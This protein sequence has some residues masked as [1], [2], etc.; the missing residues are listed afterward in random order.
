MSLLSRLMR[1]LPQAPGSG[2]ARAGVTLASGL[3]G[4][5]ALV[6]GAAPDESPGWSWPC[7]HLGHPWAFAGL[8]PQATWPWLCSDI[9]GSDPDGPSAK[10][11]CWKRPVL[12][13][14]PTAPRVGRRRS[15]PMALSRIAC[16]VG[17]WPGSRATG[18]GSQ[19][20]TDQLSRGGVRPPSGGGAGRTR[21]PSRRRARRAGGGQ[22]ARGGKEGGRAEG[23]A[24][25][26]ERGGRAAERPRSGRVPCPTT[27]ARASSPTCGGGCA[28]R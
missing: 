5:P 12:T 8:C 6:P 21:G 4:C 1:T 24:E 2:A 15:D 26:C 14:L 13:S 7:P 23:G 22:R 28:A 27:P 9:P 3:P 16:P 19:T 20:R 25:R 10:G 18:Q 17:K 11:S